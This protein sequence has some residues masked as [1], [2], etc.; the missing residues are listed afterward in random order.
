LIDDPDHSAAEDRFVL[1]GISA[2]LRVPAVVHC[3]RES[4]A[5]I[6]PISAR[7]AT[8]PECPV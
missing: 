6:R 8:R 1:L 2:M 5:R 3:Y 4:E 7:K